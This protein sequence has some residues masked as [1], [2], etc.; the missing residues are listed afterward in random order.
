MTLSSP[1]LFVGRV[2]GDGRDREAAHAAWPVQL[3][4]CEP[5]L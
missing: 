4:E 5:L 2:T 3:D 1:A